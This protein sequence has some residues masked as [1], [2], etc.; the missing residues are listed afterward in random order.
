[1]NKL[2]LTKIIKKMKRAIALF[3]VLSIFISCNNETPETSIKQSYWQPYAEANVNGLDFIN[4]YIQ[5]EINNNGRLSETK[6]RHTIILAT[7]QF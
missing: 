2:C 1:M 6:L 5:N 4:D 7:D 3:F